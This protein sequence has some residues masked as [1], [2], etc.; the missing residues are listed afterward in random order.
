MRGREPLL[1]PALV[2]LLAPGTLHLPALERRPEQIPGLAD[3]LLG[4]LAVERGLPSPQI[5][6][7]ATAALRAE[8]W[9]ENLHDLRAALQIAWDAAATRGGS[10]EI[11]AGV[12]GAGGP[13][14]GRGPG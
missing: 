3:A 2:N 11:D 1:V 8:A 7:E 13:G 14:D 6:A 10:H 12:G 4:S 9:A 5:S